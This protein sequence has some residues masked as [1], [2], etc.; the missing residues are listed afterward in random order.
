MFPK[1]PRLSLAALEAL[2]FL[3]CAKT[4]LLPNLTQAQRD[5]LQ[6]RRFSASD[7][8]LFTA[9]S[10]AL[11]DLD[12]GIEL[13]DTATGSIRS[14]LR[15]NRASMEQDNF[16]GEPAGLYVTGIRFLCRQ[17]IAASV[18]DSV[19]KLDISLEQTLCAAKGP[20]G[21]YGGTNGWEPVEMTV[22]RVSPFY[23]SVFAAIGR[24]LRE[25]R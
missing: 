12:Y 15:V 16:G 7:S 10:M 23:D 5:L 22:A 17:R 20:Y 8:A 25:K 11:A 21:P 1:Y 24:R 3:S 13:S 18:K 14:Q 6:S 19:I 4:V 2:L 9:V